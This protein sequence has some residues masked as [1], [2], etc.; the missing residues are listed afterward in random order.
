MRGS[1]EELNTDSRD[2]R[3]SRHDNRTLNR[4]INSSLEVRLMGSPGL[5]AEQGQKIAPLPEGGRLEA[6]G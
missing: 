6:R 2:V 4:M 5:E 3:H 1:G